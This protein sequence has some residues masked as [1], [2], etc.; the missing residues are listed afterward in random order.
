MQATGVELLWPLLFLSFS[1][2][3]E[4]LSAVKSRLPEQ[5]CGTGGG[6]G[7]CRDV[8]DTG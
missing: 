3:G 8:D 6:T 5:M 2:L 4:G 7:K 1:C